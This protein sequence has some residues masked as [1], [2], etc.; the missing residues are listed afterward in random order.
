MPSDAPASPSPSVRRG[1]ILFIV[2][3]AAFLNPFTASSIDLA[4]PTIA[5]EFSIDAVILPWIPSAY[6]LSLIVLLL[7][8]GRWGDCLGRGRVFAAGIT[9]Y[10][11]A[12]ALI[13]FTPN[14][15]Y[16]LSCRFLQGVGSAMVFSTNVAIIAD[17]YPPGERGRALGINV[18]A[19]YAGLSM[20]PF[21][22]GI[23]TE[24]FGWRSIFLVSLAIGALVLLSLRWFPPIL[25]E[26][27][28]SR[29]DIPG[30]IFTALTLSC[31]FLGL[32][33]MTDRRG[34]FFLLLT[35]IFALFLL[36]FERTAP[37]ALIPLSLFRENAMFTYSNLAALINYAATF[38]VALMMS[39]YL[40]YIHG[41]SPAAAGSIL[42]IQP[43][44]QVVC[45]P[46]AGR[47]SDRYPPTIIASI[48]LLVSSVSL[49]FLGRLTA[50]SPVM[51]IIPLLANL[52]LGLA[53]FSAPNTNAVMSSVERRHYG[54][55]AAMVATM[56]S[57]GMIVSMGVVMVA[58]SLFIGATEITPAVYPSFLQS[59]Q[60]IFSMFFILTLI[61]AVVSWRR[62]M[63]TAKE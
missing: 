25:N 13:L 16:L 28:L 23:L 50:D 21:L 53:L 14:A 20:G 11:A 47:L 48:G 44:I 62:V 33:M 51:A 27:T 1:L 59:M 45:S 43:F 2:T 37:D 19:V 22:G 61:G 8:A 46:I 15:L 3:L 4:L 6:L 42:L 24:F 5:A 34:V 17:L 10:T 63:I 40:Q 30:A 26:C 57:L 9:I 60:A 36:R 54:L 35:A 18:T 32:S 31:F 52:G 38:A 7:P 12:T 39:R 56:R 55:A 29:F 49:F 58:F 41:L